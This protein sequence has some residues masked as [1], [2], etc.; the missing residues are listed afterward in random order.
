MLKVINVTKNAVLINYN[1][2]NNGDIDSIGNLIL[3]D[4]IVDSCV[5]GAGFV[6][7]VGD[8]NSILNFIDNN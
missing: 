2:D 8:V 1:K 6:F 4:F 7:L 5:D 3:K